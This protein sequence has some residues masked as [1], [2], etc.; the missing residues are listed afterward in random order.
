MLSYDPETGAF[1]WLKKPNRCIPLGSQ[2]GNKRPDGYFEICLDGKHMLSH[3]LAWALMTGAWPSGLIDHVDRDRSNNRWANLR[4]G[5]KSLNAQ[6]TSAIRSS[7]GFRGVT[8]CRLTGRFVAYI[9][10]NGARKYLGR[11]KTAHEAGSAYE[12]AR[13]T[14]HPWR[15]S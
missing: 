4:E 8:P 9:K 2:A 13:K 15:P 11:F 7:T 3:R 5:N 14:A 6:N 12:I 10:V 1:R